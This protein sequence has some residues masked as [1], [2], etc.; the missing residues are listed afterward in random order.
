M[1]DDAYEYST[2]DWGRRTRHIFSN[3][4]TVPKFVFLSLNAPHEPVAATNYYKKKMKKLHPGMS[5]T[6][7]EFL[8]AVRAIDVAIRKIV[9]ELKQL[10]RET[11]LF[12][13]SDNGGTILSSGRDKT[14]RGCNYP[15]R[16]IGP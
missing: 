2:F 10:D 13:Q 4:T 5:A 11:I 14:P 15:Y 6:R 9:D 7:I 12:F 3:G 8:A 1:E 16:N